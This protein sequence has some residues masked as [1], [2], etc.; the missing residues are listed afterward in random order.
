MRNLIATLIMILG[1][2]ALP[3]LAQT[4]NPADTGADQNSTM[5]TTQSTTTTAPATNY[6]QMNSTQSGATTTTAPASNYDTTDTSTSS[7]TSTAAPTSSASSW[8]VPLIIGVLL[9][10]GLAWLMGRG[11]TDRTTTAVN[12]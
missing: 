4:N 3:A 2:F 8:A 11:G 12:T 7:T 5:P 9:V 10:I 6:D 1:F